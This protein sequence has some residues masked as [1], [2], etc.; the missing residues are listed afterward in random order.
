MT[1]TYGISDWQVSGV[2]HQRPVIIVRALRNCAAPVITRAHS[3]Q[4]AQSA[5]TC[6]GERTRL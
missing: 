2:R 1:G 4:D 5:R 6:A 3:A